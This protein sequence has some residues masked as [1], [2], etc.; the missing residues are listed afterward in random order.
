MV[1]SLSALWWRRI[2][3]LWKLPDGRDWLR[4]KLG[5]VLIGRAMLSKFLIQFSD[6]AV[7]PPCCLKWGQTMV[8]VMKIMATSKHHHKPKP[9][10]ETPG[11]SW[12]SLSQSLPSGSFHKPL[13]HQRADRMKTAITENWSNWSHGAQ[14]CLSQWNYEPC[15]VRIPKTDGSSWRVLTKRGPQE[16]GMA[17]HFSILALGTPWTVWKGKKIGHWKMNSPG[18]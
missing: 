17:N 3:G 8:E 11:Q 14:P 4:G 7:F 10:P 15:R 18:R 1:F 16:K 12:A 6:G 2:R 13:S 9:Q 5:L